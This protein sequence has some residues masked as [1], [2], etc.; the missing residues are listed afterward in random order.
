ML[1]TDNLTALAPS[2]WTRTRARHVWRGV[3][4]IIVIDNKKCDHTAMGL[5]EIEE[6]KNIECFVFARHGHRL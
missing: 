6:E 5:C 4:I 2:E 3:P 1:A